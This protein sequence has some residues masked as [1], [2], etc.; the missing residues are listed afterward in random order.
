MGNQTDSCRQSILIQWVT[1][2]NIALR[3][4]K[5]NI[6]GFGKTAATGEYMLQISLTFSSIND[7]CVYN[8]LYVMQ[9]RSYCY[10]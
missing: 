1:P 8:Q 5:P 3:F 9:Y 6:N 7:I 10:V 4:A 2:I